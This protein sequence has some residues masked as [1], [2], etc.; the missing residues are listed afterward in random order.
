IYLQVV[1]I[2]RANYSSIMVTN[3]ILRYHIYGVE[4]NDKQH[5]KEG[6]I[7]S[8]RKPFQ[9]FISESKSSDLRT[10]S[11][12]APT[13]L[14]GRVKI[15]NNRS[16]SWFLC[17]NQWEAYSPII[18]VFVKQAEMIVHMNPQVLHVI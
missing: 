10:A 6:V 9:D 15:I 3:I 2:P 11:L 14:K 16:F 18:F 12:L 7:L 5:E 8:I 1:L 17:L 13:F 4:S